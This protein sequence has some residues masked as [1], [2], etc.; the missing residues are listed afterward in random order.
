LLFIIDGFMLRLGKF[1]F[2][3][4]LVPSLVTLFFLALLL[5][6]GFWQL[7]RA[8]QKAVLQQR[9]TTQITAPYREISQVPLD[10]PISRYRKVTS[11]GHYDAKHQ[12]LLDN[13]IYQG[14]PGYHVFTPLQ[15]IGE[16]T[17]ILI[18]R[19]WVPLGES[20]QQ[21]PVVSVDESNRVVKGRVS[22]PA[23][24]GLRLDG[25]P[26]SPDD[27]WPRVVQYLDYDQLAQQLGYPL[28]PAVILLDPDM[29]DGYL[30]AWRPTFGGLGPARHRGYAVQWFSL[31]AALAIIYGVINTRRQGNY[32]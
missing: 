7:D 1:V 4:A 32:H 14:R 15:R 17:A 3:P 28:E 24:P 16:T 8:K 11:Q 10:N 30:R 21:L 23:N 20:R 18:N 6:L 12:I 13:K 22:Q 2:Q 27:A 26:P 9:F 29:E 31:A 5:S 25:S 19:G